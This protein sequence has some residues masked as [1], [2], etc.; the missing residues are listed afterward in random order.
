VTAAR[1]RSR[2]LPVRLLTTG[3]TISTADDPATGRSRPALDGAAIAALSADTAVQAVELV[4]SPSWALS[5]PDMQAVALAIRDEARTAA[6]CGLVVTVGTSALEY[7]S[8]LTDLFLDTDVPVVFTGA[9]RTADALAPD[10]PG[11][12]RDAFAVARSE[13]AR[14][15]GALV[16]FAG[17]VMSA[18]GVWKRHRDANDAFVDLGGDLGT[19]IEGRVRY[20]RASAPRLNLRG[21]I[22]PTVGMVKAF[23]GAD[24]T[25]LDALTGQGVRG[26][27]LEGLP[28]AGGVPPAMQAALRRAV[29]SGALVAISSRAP[30]GRVPTPPTG[31][32]GSPLD[33]L[34]LLSAGNLSTEKA[35][36]LLSAVLGQ[37]R[38]GAEARALF[39][40][41]SGAAA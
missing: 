15:R 13:D 7:L 32:T 23:P 33:V 28:G 14:D 2:G 37:T 29:E 19:V 10:G 4:R 41:F 36:V 8:Y 9:M 39:G 30:Y 26:L 12:L 6:F 38:D 1:V 22:D 40:A 27:V 17:R 16:C 24:G 3:G 5:L 18:R 20:T 35:W 34:P 21:E 11:N 31:G 25:L